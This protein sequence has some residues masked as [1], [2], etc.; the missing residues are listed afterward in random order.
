MLDFCTFKKIDS[1]MH[2]ENFEMLDNF[3]T[4]KKIDSS[5]LNRKT[6]L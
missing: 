3:C 1:E 5:L 2:S 6:D 4:L